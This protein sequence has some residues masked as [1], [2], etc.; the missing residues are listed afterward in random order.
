M[1]KWPQTYDFWAV[2]T[3][4]R[5]GGA[6]LSRRKSD[7][8]WW[9]NKAEIYQVGWRMKLLRTLTVLHLGHVFLASMLHPYE[10]YSHCQR[11]KKDGRVQ[12]EKKHR[13]NWV[14]SANSY[15]NLPM[16]HMGLLWLFE[17]LQ[18]ISR[19]PASK[20]LHASTRL[21][22]EVNQSLK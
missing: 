18:Q 4:A 21:I 14:L 19:S 3:K 6:I 7:E 12:T 2:S 15:T 16:M 13:R 17:N 5:V 9:K 11:Y 1:I 8:K 10:D 20:S 22:S